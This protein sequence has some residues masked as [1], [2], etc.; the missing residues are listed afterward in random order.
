MTQNVD[1]SLF[2]KM[3]DLQKTLDAITDILKKN[4]SQ[5]E[6]TDQIKA[7]AMKSNKPVLATLLANIYDA[8]QPLST[9]CYRPDNSQSQL[10]SSDG[11]FSKAL[12]NM[13]KRSD[14]KFD[15]LQTQLT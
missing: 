3:E 11:S 9:S 7:A 2:K 12:E 6:T 5:L 14:E 8:A 15:S 13:Q 10:N 1:P 4:S